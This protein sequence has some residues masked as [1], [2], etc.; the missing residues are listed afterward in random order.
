MP[1]SRVV[2][3]AVLALA[4]LQ[5]AAPPPLTVAAAISLTDAL[6]EVAR[7]YAAAGGGQVR[8]NFAGSNVLA[9]QI[10][11]GAPADVFISAD[12]AQMD[13]AERAGAI[14]RATRVPLLGNRLAVITRKG[15]ATGSRIRKVD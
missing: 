4:L 8:F 1:L 13:V 7:A 9:R 12:E 5:P 15:S 3:A 11:N 6:E 14:D 2:I 10:I